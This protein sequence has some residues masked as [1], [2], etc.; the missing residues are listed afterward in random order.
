MAKV[1][2]NEELIMKSEELKVENPFGDF[3]IYVASLIFV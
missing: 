1:K 3:R 2:A